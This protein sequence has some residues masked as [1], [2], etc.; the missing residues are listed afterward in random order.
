MKQKLPTVQQFMARF[1]DDAAC[2]DHLMR[3]R[4][5]ERFTCPKCLKEARYYRV[6][7][8]RSY[9]CEHCGNQVY[10]TAGT[11][12][13]KTRT[14]LKDWFYVMFLFCASRNGV[15]AKEVQRQIGVTYKTAWRMCHEIRTYM[16]F[17]DGDAPLGGDYPG[18]PVVEID[19][20]FVGGKD[21]M[22]EGDKMVVIGM[23]ERAGQAI[24]RHI[25]TRKGRHVLPV[26]GKWVKKGSKVATDEAGVFRNLDYTYRHGMVDHSAKEWVRGDVHTNSI[27]ALWANLKRGVEGTYVHVSAQH[28]PKYLAEFEFRHNLR[29]QP[30]LMFELLL[31]AFPRGLAPSK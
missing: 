28:L 18:A 13:E 25:P 26:I 2:L 9:E 3:T 20:T 22:G 8:R 10:P 11:P 30:A 27:E 4:Y 14:S 21:K 16:G 15:A 5:G 19:K 29:K 12:F 1:P 7:A 31:Q 23:V 17:V 24:L 6:K